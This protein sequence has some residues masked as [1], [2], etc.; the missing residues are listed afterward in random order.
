MRR[1]NQT[2]VYHLSTLAIGFKLIIAKKQNNTVFLF[3]AFK[4]AKTLEFEFTASQIRGASFTHK[5]VEAWRKVPLFNRKTSIGHCDIRYQEWSERFKVLQR[6]VSITLVDLQEPWMPLN[7]GDEFL[8]F[9]P[10][11][12]SFPSVISRSA[13]SRAVLVLASIATSV[14]LIDVFRR[15]ATAVEL[16]SG[17]S[18][19]ELGHTVDLLL[20]RAGG[21]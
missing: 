9:C 7:R 16:Q 21:K 10:V 5:G 19:T 1:F 13:G 4:V 14:Y 3:Y 2:V 8:F 6:S 11:L 17:R 12:V 15:Q 20:L 18:R